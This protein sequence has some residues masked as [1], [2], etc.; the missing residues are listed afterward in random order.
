M[1][2]EGGSSGPFSLLGLSPTLEHS[3]PQ[4]KRGSGR[5]SPVT[6]GWARPVRSLE[7]GGRGST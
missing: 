4:K 2:W 6:G 5:Q 1:G 7:V 3:P